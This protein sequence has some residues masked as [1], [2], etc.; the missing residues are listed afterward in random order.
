MDV[1]NEK[2]TYKQELITALIWALVE[3]SQVEGQPEAPSWSA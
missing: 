3:L 1:R 2:N